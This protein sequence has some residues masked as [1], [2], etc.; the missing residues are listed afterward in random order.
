VPTGT[1][2]FSCFHTCSSGVPRKFQLFQAPQHDLLPNWYCMSL[3]VVPWQCCRVVWRCRSHQTQGTSQA[4]PAAQERASARR[5]AA[6]LGE[7]GALWAARQKRGEAR[8]SQALLG[9]AFA[10]WQCTAEVKTR[11]WCVPDNALAIVDET[12]CSR[13]ERLAVL[14]EDSRVLRSH[15]TV[16]ELV[17]PACV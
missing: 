9:R 12:D 17:R 11:S 2:T 1:G 16:C 3:G 8:A 14:L 4:L 6:L 13:Q 5:Q 15:S 7:W 10:G